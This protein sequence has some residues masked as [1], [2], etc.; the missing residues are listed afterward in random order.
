M[1]ER[2]QGRSQT[3]AAAKAALSERSAR[4]IDHGELTPGPKPMRHWRTRQDPLSAV[5]KDELLPLLEDNPAL[6][7]M[8]LL[9]YLNDHYPGRFGDRIQR[10]LQR[11]VK[12][13]RAQHGPAKEVM[14]RQ[15]KQPGQ[16]GLSD[17]TQLKGVVVTIANVDHYRLAFSGWCHVKVICGGESYTALAT[18][19]Q[20]AFWRSGGVPKE[21]RTD[22]LSAAYNNLS[23]QEA[24]TQRYQD[25]CRHYGT[26]ATRNNPGKS[27]ENGAI[28][29]PHGHLKRR[30]EQALLLRGS[31]D[32]SSLEDYQTFID[33]VV[34][35]INQRSQ[36]RWQPIRCHPDS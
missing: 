12:A 18:G 19:L 20:D 5:W 17:F 13:W 23:E 34:S 22:S 31:H 24:L 28:E 6:Q 3:T 27:H 1:N 16:L 35:R 11:R 7:P 10:T 4:R 30:I 14:F 21:H 9:D 33:Q 36:S 32:F 15:T 2:K 29:S 8:T 25:L 26:R